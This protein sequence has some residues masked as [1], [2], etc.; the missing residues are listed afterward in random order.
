[1]RLKQPFLK[2]PIRFDADALAAEARALPPSA[3]TP[4][5]TGFVGNEAVRLVTPAGEDSDNIEGPMAATDSLNRCHY[6]RQIMAEIGVSGA[7]AG[8]WA[9]RRDGKCRRTSISI[10]TGARTC[11]FTFR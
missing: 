6:V 1:M 3:W 10:I 11:A 7:A 2:L 4:H 8:S 9:W 5:P